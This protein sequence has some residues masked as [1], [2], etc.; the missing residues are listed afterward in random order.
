MGKLRFK[1][2]KRPKGGCAVHATFPV[3]GPQRRTVSNTSMARQA[4]QY[5]EGKTEKHDCSGSQELRQ[6]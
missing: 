4:G 1:A 3:L 6:P 5:K 2:A